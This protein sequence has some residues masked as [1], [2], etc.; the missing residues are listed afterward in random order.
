MIALLLVGLVVWVHL[1]T[2]EHVQQ[3]QH[4]LQNMQNIL[5]RAD[6]LQ[7]ELTQ[8]REHIQH[9]EE[10]LISMESQSETN[11][12]PVAPVAAT[13]T[14]KI[15]TPQTPVH[16]IAQKIIHQTKNKLAPTS[17]W[18]VIIASFDTLEKAKHAQQRKRISALHSSITMVKIKHR[19]WYR[20]VRPGFKDKASAIDFSQKIKRLG[21]HDAW[22]QHYP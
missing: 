19:T 22:L 10:K 17:D 13:K 11:I 7:P 2:Q 14:I 21:F 6:S 5:E 4:K 9:I 1:S 16:P 12:K 20:I 15:I 18:M 3:L 8:M